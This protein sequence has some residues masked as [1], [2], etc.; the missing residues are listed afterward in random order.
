M[1]PLANF[2]I[3]LNI[4]MSIKFHWNRVQELSCKKDKNGQNFLK[5]R[6]VKTC[7]ALPGQK[8]MIVYHSQKVKYIYNLYLYRKLYHRTLSFVI[9]IFFLLY[10]VPYCAFII[11]LLDTSFVVI[12]FS[13]VFFSFSND[14]EK[15]ELLLMKSSPTEGGGLKKEK[16]QKIYLKI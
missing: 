5:N 13:W 9:I 15:K 6:R 14:L 1:N 12:L 16:W 8:K 7:R 11:L 4:N 3:M 2:H 10:H